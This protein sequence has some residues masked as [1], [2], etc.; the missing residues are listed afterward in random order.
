MSE[1]SCIPDTSYTCVRCFQ[2]HFQVIVARFHCFKVLIIY[3]D[4]TLRSPRA[5]TINDVFDV[6]RTS[7]VH[8]IIHVRDTPG[9]PLQTSSK[10]PASVAST[11]HDDDV[12]FT[13]RTS[14]S[15]RFTSAVFFNG[16]A[17]CSVHE[18]IAAYVLDT[19]LPFHSV[20]GT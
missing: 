18:T 4:V 13:T 15:K 14:W 10:A 17:T 19:A 7:Q 3:A 12:T 2:V 1:T 8:R 16:P 5:V 20:A 9:L 11:E 6:S